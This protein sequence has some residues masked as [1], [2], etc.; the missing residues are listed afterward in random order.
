[1]EKNKNLF[2]LDTK[3]SS[4]ISKQGGHDMIKNSSENKHISANH[5]VNDSTAN[6]DNI[7]KNYVEVAKDAW[8]R[9]EPGTYI[10]Y[11]KT[12]GSLK[13]GGRIKSI[14]PTGNGSISISIQKFRGKMHPLSWKVNSNSIS[15][16]YR[17]KN[18]HAITGGSP[19]P[20][21]NTIIPQ[22]Q[23]NTL[24]DQLGDKFLFDDKDVLRKKIENLETKVNKIEQDL[25]N[26]FLFVKKMYMP[27]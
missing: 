21:V 1:M 2:D 4:I 14:E 18:E 5:T 16:I 15:K 17:L 23:S 10:R 20:P 19:T 6:I 9:L 25:K 12:D 8:S 11:M 7:L 24:L 27:K 13:S 26:L 3:I 22:P